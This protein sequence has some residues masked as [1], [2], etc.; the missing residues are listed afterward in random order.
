MA[1]SMQAF[2]SN[3]LE[4]RRQNAAAAQFNAQLKAQQQQQMA[5]AFG[6]LPSQ[7]GGSL[8]KFGQQQ[9]QDRIYNALGEQFFGSDLQQIP[10]ATA[11]DPR[12]QGIQN[13][14]T[15]G[16]SPAYAPRGSDLSGGD[17]TYTPPPAPFTGGK[18]GFAARLALMEAQNK[19][20]NQDLRTQLGASLMETRAANLGVAQ[21][22][23]ENAQARTTIAQQA[24]SLAE[25]EAGRK[26]DAERRLQEGQ[27]AREAQTA[28]EKTTGD[29][30]N[31]VASVDNYNKQTRIMTAAIQHAAAESDRNAYDS[32]VDGLHAHWYATK[33]A[34]A[35]DLPEPTF[36]S[37][38]EVQDIAAQQD[39]VDAARAQIANPTGWFT[40]KEERQ[41]RYEAEQQKLQ[42]MPGYKLLPTQ[43]GT[44]KLFQAAPE[45]PDYTKF[46]EQY[47]TQH[48][49]PGS[50]PSP[51]ATPAGAGG[52]TGTISLQQART[53][54]PNVQ[55]GDTLT[56]S[57]GNR[58]IVVQ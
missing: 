25:L 41:A 3:M 48:P 45:I 31:T 54:H 30:K 18:E 51:G 32:A 27:W 11:V 50:A 15:T 53:K 52:A 29:Y 39:K 10:R 49:M 16:M 40:S 36:P 21:G 47:R 33:N 58:V 5:E 42:S 9:K 56:D 1:Q 46:M 44:E 14:F 23:L 20:G 37:F 34:G 24:Q 38:D 7:I 13:Q 19:M 35:K 12:L 17:I 4:M 28:F 57:A 6:D 22:N 43:Q 55:V 8:V 26:A 2:I